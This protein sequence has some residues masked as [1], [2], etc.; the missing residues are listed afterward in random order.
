[1]FIDTLMTIDE[2][3]LKSEK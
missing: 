3:E 1:V 2:Q